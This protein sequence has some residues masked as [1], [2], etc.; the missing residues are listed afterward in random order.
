MTFSTRMFLRILPVRNLTRV[1]R[2]LE[3]ASGLGRHNGRGVLLARKARQQFE[4]SS[5]H[6]LWEALVDDCAGGFVS[7]EGYAW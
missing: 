5:L 4:D 6:G 7:G 2:P 3:A 1:S